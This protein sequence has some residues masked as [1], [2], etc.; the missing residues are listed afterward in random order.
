MTGC[1]GRDG[2]VR[3]ITIRG[4]RLRLMMGDLQ[5]HVGD[6]VERQVGADPFCRVDSGLMMPLDD[7]LNAFLGFSDFKRDSSERGDN[8]SFG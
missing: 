5:W 7:A 3:R 6:A 4:K 2:M 1:A 8:G